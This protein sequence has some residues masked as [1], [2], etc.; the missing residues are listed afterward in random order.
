MKSGPMLDHAQ[1]KYSLADNEKKDRNG[2]LKA[3]K[4]H[5]EY[6]VFLIVTN[7]MWI[8]I[9]CT[10]DDKINMFCFVYID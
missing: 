8:L 5:R 1:K 7:L 6:N 10:F 2:R 3:K 9:K 4:N